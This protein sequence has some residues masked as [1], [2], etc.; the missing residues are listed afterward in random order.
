MNA[1]DF[2]ALDRDLAAGNVSLDRDTVLHYALN[3]FRHPA[4]EE[5]Q[6]VKQIS[7][8]SVETLMVCR[9]YGLSA[10]TGV[11]EIGAYIGGSTVALGKGL[12]LAGRKPMAT[13]DPGGSVLDQPFL[14]SADIL[15]DWH[16]NVSSFGLEGVS[17]LVKGY[18]QDKR[19]I[20]EVKE[21]AAGSKFDVFFMDTNGEVHQALNDYGGMLADDCLVILDD[22]YNVIGADTKAQ[23]TARQVHELM[24]IGLLEQYA[25]VPFSTW[26]GRLNKSGIKKEGRLSRLVRK[27][28]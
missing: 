9:A 22:Y 25:L 24:A 2:L 15:A 28:R 11:L 10:K 16:K 26:F 17:K 21:V 4:Y 1:Q 27:F 7:M 14:P 13:I 20:S 12:H 18:S 8:L 3:C 5:M 23:K 6:A 19:V